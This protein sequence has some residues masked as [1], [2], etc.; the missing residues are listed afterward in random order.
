MVDQGEYLKRLSLYTRLLAE[1]AG[2]LR[3][4]AIMTPRRPFQWR[5][6]DVES[7]TIVEI[8]A[9]DYPRISTIHR[10]S[11]DDQRVFLQSFLE[12][13]SRKLRHRLSRP[14]DEPS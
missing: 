10:L 6:Y 11:K 9:P 5:L 2:N 3:V 4:E 7:P 12:V 8:I 1:R 13:S 14:E